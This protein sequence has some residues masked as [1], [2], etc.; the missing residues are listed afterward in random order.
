M[1]E[2]SLA[3][4]LIEQVDQELADRGLVDLSEVHLAIGEF[5]GVEPALLASAFDEL[6]SQHWQRDVRLKLDIVLVTA[7]C[8]GCGS[9]FRVE[10]FHFACPDCRSGS[11]K[12]IQGEEMQLV[13]LTAVR[14]D[15]M[16]SFL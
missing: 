4:R 6:A 13:S 3:A 16:G 9:T 11:V 15:S 5:S 7:Q 1:H 2:R 10:R 8:E 12:V 14:R